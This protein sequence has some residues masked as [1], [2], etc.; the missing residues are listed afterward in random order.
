MELTV[1]ALKS[2]V[3][4]NWECAFLYSLWNYIPGRWSLKIKCGV[5]KVLKK[6]QKMGTIFCMNP[7]KAIVSSETTAPFLSFLL[8]S[9]YW[10]IYQLCSSFKL[11]LIA[12]PSWISVQNIHFLIRDGSLFMG[13][14]GSGKNRTGFE[15]F[16]CRGDGLCVFFLNKEQGSQ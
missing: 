14:T 13:V 11:I 6:S 12:L 2:P 4:M 15:N 1:Q 9:M 16:S 7:V 5:W 3:R 10:Q 8:V